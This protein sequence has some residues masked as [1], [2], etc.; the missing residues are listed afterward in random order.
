MSDQLISSLEP[1]RLFSASFPELPAGI[2]PGDLENFNGVLID[3]SGFPE[4]PVTV[5]VTAEGEVVALPILRDGVVTG[6]A[7]TG[8]DSVLVQSRTGV[9]ATSTLP[10]IVFFGGVESGASGVQIFGSVAEAVAS[11]DSI[12]ESLDAALTSLQNTRSILASMGVDTSALDAQLAEIAQQF[13]DVLEALNQTLATPFVRVTVAG[14]YD[15]YFSADQVTDVSIDTGGGDDLVTSTL[16]KSGRL[17]ISDGAG[18]DTITSVG[19]ARLL[20]GAGNDRL[21]A[22]AASVLDGGL[23]DDV[24]VGSPDSDTLVGGGGNDTYVTGNNRAGVMDIV[25]RSFA[26][27]RFSVKPFATKLLAANKD[28]L[29]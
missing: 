26:V 13:A 20:G 28:L 21:V 2:N 4:S 6:T 24:L 9:D 25:R 3:A 16:A 11:F 10:G 23:G 22:S 8:A 27:D 17:T 19:S 12:T 7:T 14:Q 18:N 5:Q 1:R 15:A 29:A